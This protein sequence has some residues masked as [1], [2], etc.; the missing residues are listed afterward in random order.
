MHA[1]MIFCWMKLGIISMYLVF[2][3]EKI[4]SL[5]EKPCRD[6]FLCDMVFAGIM[7]RH[8]DM[9]KT[10]CP[11]FILHFQ[12]KSIGVVEASSKLRATYG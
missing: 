9:Q 4:N 10:D 11:S 1:E 7:L 8:L 5:L 12:A 2:Q 3:I 6:F